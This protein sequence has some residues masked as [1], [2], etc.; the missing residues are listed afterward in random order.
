MSEREVL[1]HAPGNLTLSVVG[2]GTARRLTVAAN[3][4]EAL[5]DFDGVSFASADGVTLEAPLS[6]ANALAVRAHVPWLQPQPV[7]LA[8]SAGVGDRL[9]LA[10]PGHARAFREHGTD[11]VP[12]FAQQSAREMDRLGRSP[13]EVLDDATFGALD[14]GWDRPVGADADHLKTTTDV[15]RC[16]DAGFAS[17]TIDPGE[18]VRVVHPTWSG[19]L[20]DLPWAALE[21]DESSMLRRYSDVALDLGRS[22]LRVS[23]EELRVAAYKYATAVS[24]TAAMYRHLIE[25]ADYPVEVE[26]AIDETESPTTIV[27]HLYMATELKRLG[28][29]WVSFAPRYVGDFEKGVEYLGDTGVLAESLRQH[30]AVATAFGPY[31]ISLHSGSDKFS[32]YALAAEATGG[33]LHLKTSGTSYLE[34]L[35]VAASCAPTLFRSI[36]DVSRHAFET[37]RASYQVSAVMERVPLSRHVRDSELGALVTSFDSR[38]MLHVGYGAVLTDEDAAGRRWLNDALRQL[39]TEESARYEEALATHLGRH[40]APLE[41]AVR[42]A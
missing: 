14:A 17:F 39:L 37:T 3:S 24:Y 20:D 35:G 29:R 22:S 8:T 27:E 1:V 40:L 30:F 36:Y 12:V 11:L 16:L 5:S 19:D 15:D 26:V 4:A 38:Q 33:M 9:G 28:V 23:E 34:A 10:T 42:R 6:H 21:D 7:G 31:K 25:H 32:I 2:K 41:E 18:H 13:R